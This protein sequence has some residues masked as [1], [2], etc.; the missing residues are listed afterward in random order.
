MEIQHLKEGTRVSIDISWLNGIEGESI[1][2]VVSSL[3]EWK[4]CD[5]T[6]DYFNGKH[7]NTPYAKVRY[8]SELNVD[9]H[10]FREEFYFSERL[11][12]LTIDKNQQK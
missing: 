1:T 10:K 5:N 9:G 2:G 7:Y 12:R 6:L 11:S 4:C 8:D 3:G